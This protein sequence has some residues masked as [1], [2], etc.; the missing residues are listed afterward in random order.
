MFGYQSSKIVTINPVKWFEPCQFRV[1]LICI[2]D[3]VLQ[4]LVALLLHPTA[5]GSIHTPF[6]II[7]EVSD[8]YL[9][10]EWRLSHEVQTVGDGIKHP[11]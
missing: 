11:S 7:I 3:K 9:F 6:T 1:S 10:F 8:G 4:R 2:S 5:G